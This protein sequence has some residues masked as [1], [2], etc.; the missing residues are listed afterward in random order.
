ME[1]R[2]E[3]D[4]SSLGAKWSVVDRSFAQDA[5]N[6]E[7]LDMMAEFVPLESDDFLTTLPSQFPCLLEL[8]K[9]RL[10]ESFL[11]STWNVP[12]RRNAFHEA[13]HPH[14]ARRI[15]QIMERLNR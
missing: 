5:T 8:G 15:E 13:T 4:L 3:E 12:M 11:G 7:S 9:I 6:L 10:T 1:W 14:L 2:N